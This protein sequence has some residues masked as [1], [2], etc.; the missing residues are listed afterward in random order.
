MGA[1]LTKMQNMGFAVILPLE[2]DQD[3][4]V[5][6]VTGAV[7]NF[8]SLGVSLVGQHNSV[9][10]RKTAIINT[11][12]YSMQFLQRYLPDDDSP[13]GGVIDTTSSSDIQ[14]PDTVYTGTDGFTFCLTVDIS[15]HIIGFDELDNHYLAKIYNSNFLK[16]DTLVRQKIQVYVIANTYGLQVISLVLEI[17]DLNGDSKIYEFGTFSYA[18]I[19]NH[20]EPPVKFLTATF[21]LASSGAPYQG[22][23]TGYL[24]GTEVFTGNEQLNSAFNVMHL[25][26]SSNTY[27]GIDPE[28]TSTPTS[29]EFPL[30]VDFDASISFGEDLD[31]YYW[32][33]GDGNNGTGVFVT[34]IYNTPGTYTVSLTVTNTALL[35]VTETKTDL[36]V[37]VAPPIISQDQLTD[38]TNPLV[39]G[40]TNPL[41][42]P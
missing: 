25:G 12:N 18:D 16:S 2:E 3:Y 6:Q 42:Q 33:F 27:S 40:S 21:K 37:V 1:Y 5:G 32:V 9:Y 34:H 7:A 22:V 11:E 19:I 36:I 4:C 24:D 38:G 41:T 8:G 13:C 14:F 15:D 39:D 35:S 31:T 20:T 17:N 23:L 30:F 28:F 10:G 26:Q 29:G